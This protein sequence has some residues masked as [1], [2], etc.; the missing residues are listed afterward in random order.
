MS[1]K[2]LYPYFSAH[3]G[4]KEADLIA[5][6]QFCLEARRLVVDERAADQLGRR[7]EGAGQV[8][9]QVGHGGAHWQLDLKGHGSIWPGVVLAQQRV[10]P[11]KDVNRPASAPCRHALR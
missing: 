5:V 8:L 3:D 11:D 2:E 9:S 6:V 1:P 4:R 7:A 10:Q